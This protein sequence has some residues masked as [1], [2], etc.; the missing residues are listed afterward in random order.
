MLTHVYIDSFL[1]FNNFELSI[2]RVT[3]LVGMN[4]TGKTSVLELVDAVRRFIVE[5]ISV[6]VFAPSKKLTC[7]DTRNDQKISL[8]AKVKGDPF[9]YELVIRHTDDRLMRKVLTEKLSSNGQTLFLYD[10][11]ATAHLYNDSGVEKG[12]IEQLDWNRSA[13]GWIREGHENKRLSRFRKWLEQIQLARPDVQDT[14]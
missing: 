13:L 9:E 3:L 7:W 8:T 14:V 11:H 4:G 10:E 6:D 2:D 1:C 5:G 12:K